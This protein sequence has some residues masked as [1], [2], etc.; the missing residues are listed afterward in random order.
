MNAP[1]TGSSSYGCLH[2]V[3]LG[4]GDPE[5]LTVKA[6]RLIQ[7]APVV[8]YFAKAGRRGNARKIVD[9]WLLKSCEELPLHYPVTT[10]IPFDHPHYIAA[11]ASFYEASASA[12]AERLQAGRDVALLSEGD[13]LFYGSFMH[14]FVRLKIALSCPRSCPAIT[15]NVRMSGGGASS[16]RLG[17]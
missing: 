13:P 10:E 11:L 12:I 3:G 8:A 16:G 14:L 15:G 9:R 6:V 1:S 2:G 4:P 17:R 7:A 5:L